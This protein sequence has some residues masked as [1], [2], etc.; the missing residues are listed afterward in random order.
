MAADRLILFLATGRVTINVIAQ[1]QYQRRFAHL[2]LLSDPSYS[3]DWIRPASIHR[4]SIQSWT[5]GRYASGCLFLCLSVPK[6]FR[7]LPP[8]PDW[9]VKNHPT[10][11]ALCS[12]DTQLYI[13]L[14]D[15]QSQI[16]RVVPSKTKIHDFVARIRRLSDGES[17]IIIS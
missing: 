6:G 9:L 2:D 14:T 16:I 15:G 1:C 7:E 3:V 4:R 8:P 5:N 13:N 11:S 17:P 12:L 10:N